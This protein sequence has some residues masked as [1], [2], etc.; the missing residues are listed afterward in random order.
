MAAAIALKLPYMKN[1][2]KKFLLK[3]LPLLI[4]AFGYLGKGLA[5]DIIAV[6]PITDKIICLH[7][8]EGHVDYS[9]YHESPIWTATYKYNSVLNT[10]AA[11]TTSNYLIKGSDGN[12]NSGKSPVY[13]GRKAKGTDFFQPD[14]WGNV[15]VN[16]QWI[17]EHW[18]YLELPNALQRGVNYTIELKNGLADNRK[19]WKFVYDEARLRSVAVHA[20]QIGYATN[21]PKYAYLSQWMGDFDHS[22]HL[23]GGLELDDLSGGKFHVVPYNDQRIAASVYSGTIAKRKEKS[24]SE[25]THADYGANKNFTFADVWECNFTNFKVP[26]EYVIVVER[27]GRSYPF[28]IG[29]D[30]YREA[31]WALS[32]GMFS[33]RA[34]IVKEMEPD[35]IW[36]RDHRLG[37]GYDVFYDT[38]YKGW[39]NTSHWTGNSSDGKPK[40]DIW[41]FYHDAGDWDR[42]LSH[43]VIPMQFLMLYDLKPKNFAD[44]DVSNRY[45]LASSDPWINEGDNGI[46]D[47]L[48]EAMWTIMSKKRGKDELIAK[49]LGTGGVPGD[50]VG[51]EGAN[52]AFPSW[53][54]S[55][56]VWLVSAESPAGTFNYA[57]LAAHYAE[58]LKKFYGDTNRVINQWKE[59][60]IAAYDWAQS[61]IS[62]NS[63]EYNENV[64]KAHA[65]AAASLYRAT[66]QTKYQDDFKLV[67]N[68]DSWFG[69]APLHSGLWWEQSSGIYA[70]LP[71]DFPGLDNTFQTTIKNK[72]IE[73][74]NALS[75]P[76]VNRGFRVGMRIDKNFAL[77]SH[78]T[79]RTQLLAMAYHIT[80]NQKYLDAI[81]TTAS[82][83]LGGNEM[84]R[85]RVTS[86]GEEHEKYV[87]QKDSWLT[88]EYGYKSKVYSTPM[89]TGLVGYFGNTQGWVKGGGNELWSQESAYPAFANWPKSEG[90]FDNIHS[91][92]G[93]EYTVHQTM[94]HA[95]FTYGYL[96]STSS[97]NYV[98]NERPDISLNLK[99]STEISKNSIYRL[100]AS[101]SGDTRRVK[102]YYEWHFIG[103]STDRDNSFAFDWNVTESNVNV[104]ENVLITAVAYDD[105]GLINRPDNDVD[106]IAKMVDVPAYTLTVNSLNGTVSKNPDKPTYTAGESVTLTASPSENYVFSNWSGSASGTTNSV[107]ITMNENKTVD[108]VFSKI[109]GI[110]NLKN[111][112][113]QIYPNPFSGQ[114]FVKNSLQ[115]DRCRVTDLSGKELIKM[116][117]KDEEIHLNYLRSGM[118][119]FFINRSDQNIQVE[120]VVKR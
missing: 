4:M 79:P 44:G 112:P 81:H 42:Y 55:R 38:T 89:V 87:F 51:K 82:Y 70:L 21:G 84:N 115:G 34:G 92:A 39:I 71:A 60:A 25:S 77:G 16:N 72:I 91:I 18:V 27:M 26:G 99:D 37:D 54:D 65:Y 5:A 98:A 32:R 74:A 68:A 59:E 95:L 83:F 101:A 50:Y 96:C 97:G 20:N 88:P 102:Y 93:S 100:T 2:K 111:N 56:G 35:V 78:S 11:T 6:Y 23:S 106:A 117:I 107:S 67:Y 90:R 105:K 13:I 49:N 66:R 85:V 114:L 57:G 43:D 52:D 7:F 30:V 62:S 41:G 94:N 8:D 19:T 17:L 53:E 46:P 31:Y 73:G 80:S 1:C 86:L 76:I 47:I 61:Y 12:Y 108:A 58:C 40:V 28:E 10:E 15:D 36:G 45:K 63:T 103:E 48:D 22:P 109:T 104:G 14:D 69:K 3:F 113:I 110:I 118:Y 116:D 24:T 120:K 29:D 75:D 119:L 33:Q 9:N 64:K